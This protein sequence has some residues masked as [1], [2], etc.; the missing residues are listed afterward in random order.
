MIRIGLVVTPVLL[1]AAG[2]RPALADPTY[3]VSAR[4]VLAPREQQHCLSAPGAGEGDCSV[5]ERAHTAFAAA[6]ARMFTPG[7][8]A[9]LELVL[10]VAAADIFVTA[11]GSLELNVRT[12]VRILTAGGKE[13]DEITSDGRVAVTA[14][15]AIAT[16]AGDA[17]ENAAKTFELSYARSSAVSDWL[18]ESAAAPAAAVSLPQR[19]DRLVSAAVGGNLVQGGGDR[20]L[21]PGPSARVGGTL[22][23][24]VLQAMYSTYASSFQGV[25]L[26][27]N[28]GSTAP[29]KL[30]VDDFGVEAGAS[31]R[32]LP[33]LEL[34]AGPGLHYL[35]GSGGF[36]NDGRPDT[37]V[38]TFKKISPS[39]FASLSTTFLPF[40]S[41]ARFFAGVEGR[42]YFAS[43]VDM[44][45]TGRRVP[46]ANT[47][48][49]LLVGIEF[50]WG[51]GE[52]RTR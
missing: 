35:S 29:A 16:A 41:G 37:F 33:A 39:A 30:R 52:G 43:T 12:R 7:T 47:S 10:T 42:A 14:Q 44:P 28:N 6:T 40:R 1:L 9:S 2:A 18:V 46:A 11:G 36:E 51:S 21:V 3:P 20:D 48:V 49:G 19:G 8:P 38:S 31:L 4:L 17:A 27:F 50:P 34:R 13:L 22:G 26:Q 5:V 15:S 45:A 25:V 24:F 32:I 23:W